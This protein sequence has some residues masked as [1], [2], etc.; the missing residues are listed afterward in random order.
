MLVLQ[1]FMVFIL[2]FAVPILVG[3]IW[4]STEKK[5]ARLSFLW[6]SGQVTLWAGFQIIAVVAIFLNKSFT[7]VCSSFTLFEVAMIFLAMGSLIG[8]RNRKSLHKPKPEP[9]QGVALSEWLSWIAFWSLAFALIL[10][11]MYYAYADGDNAYYLAIANQT[12]SSNSMYRVSPYIGLATGLDIRHALAPFP[13]W[14]AYVSRLSGLHVAII[15]Q[16]VLPIVI[17]GMYFHLTYLIAHTLLEDKK[18]YIPLFMLLSA[19]FVLFGDFSFS[20]NANFLIARTSQG[21][22]VLGNLILPFLLWI[23]WKM[24][25]YVQDK[26]AIPVTYYGLLQMVMLAGCLC[27]ALS[28]FLLVFFL[29]LVSLCVFFM[30]HTGKP[31]LWFVYSAIAPAIFAGIYFLS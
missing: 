8:R 28:C 12:V 31:I 7:T 17:L 4:V 24:L 23:V 30:Y 22:A 21:K 25:Q 19:L 1:I 29:G 5:P 15:G 6:V 11:R 3:N 9:R 13:I 16:L 14:V 18:N 2:L 26:K 27:S 10:G 20:S